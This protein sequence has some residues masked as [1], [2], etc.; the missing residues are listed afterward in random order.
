MLSDNFDG[1]P[2]EKWRNLSSIAS[3]RKINIVH[4]AALI[5]KAHYYAFFQ[6]GIVLFGR[7]Y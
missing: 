1:F 5:E 3:M 2:S 7:A 4:R 6:K